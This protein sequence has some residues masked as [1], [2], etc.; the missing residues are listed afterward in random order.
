MELLI[1][2]IVTLGAQGFKWLTT[3][4]GLDI[5]K[6]VILIIVFVFSLIASILYLAFSGTE[7]ISLT[8]WKTLV[9]V[10]SL[11][12]TWYEVVVKRFLLAIFNKK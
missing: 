10:F 5:A 7:V 8:D 4:W 11:A 12:I 6:S 3:K 1:G 2:G 9:T